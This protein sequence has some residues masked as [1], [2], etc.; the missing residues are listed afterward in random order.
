MLRALDAAGLAEPLSFLL[1]SAEHPF[2]KPDARIFRL[3]AERLGVAPERTWFVGDSWE[4]DVVGASAAGM[5]ALWIADAE[6]RGETRPHRRIA[7]LGELLPLLEE[8]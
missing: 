5:R 7:T 1:A 4:N 6:R 3:A 8:G 2:A